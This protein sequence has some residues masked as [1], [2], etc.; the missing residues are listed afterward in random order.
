MNRSGGGQ[1]KI[2]HVSG[3][4]LY[5]CSVQISRFFPLPLVFLSGKCLGALGYVLLK[6]RRRITV[7]NLM[8]ALGKSES[9]ARKLA[10]R[11][12]MNLGANILS[13]LKIVT[14]SDTRL[15]RHVTLEVAP[16]VPS[17][18]ELRGWVAAISHMGNWE[19]LGRL[20]QLFPQYRFGAIYQPLANSYVDRHFKKCR[21][22]AGLTLFNRREGFWKPLA[23]LES[24]GVLGVLIDQHAGMSG[25]P[26]PFFGREASTSTLAA[27][28]ALRAG[29]PVIP[30]TMNTVGLSRWRVS[31]GHPI[32]S[33]GTPLELTAAMNRELEKQIVASPADWLWSH[34]R[35]KYKAA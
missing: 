18:P 7:E 6:K 24:G 32:Q 16:E 25:T 19:L 22:R 34:N 2:L 17:G 21:S 33:G 23:F 26:M 29:V 28:M 4:A 1:F 15:R 27:S 31:I 12:F 3:Y 13:M 11:H 5:L 8:M 14:M 20:A 10:L 30:I 9:E 35:W